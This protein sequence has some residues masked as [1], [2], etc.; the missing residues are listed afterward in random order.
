MNYA[1]SQNTSPAPKI[2]NDQQN[3][4]T[5]SPQHRRLA[6]P[7]LEPISTQL[8]GNSHKSSGNGYNKF[9]T[10]KSKERVS[11]SKEKSKEN[12][13]EEKLNRVKEAH[14]G[15]YAKHSNYYCQPDFSSHGY[16]PYYGNYIEN[17]QLPEKT[18]PG[19]LNPYSGSFEPDNNFEGKS[20]R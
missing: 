2:R 10:Q 4:E 11:K 1:K 17:E 5:K 12:S 15:N 9:F 16:Q 18:S 3:E 8:Q 6:P 7:G 20:R 19:N 14:G 13:P